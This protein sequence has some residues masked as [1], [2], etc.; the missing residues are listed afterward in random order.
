MLIDTFDNTSLKQRIY[1]CLRSSHDYVLNVHLT[2]DSTVTV[3]IGGY[4]NLTR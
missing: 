3:H 2:L 1:I 4:I